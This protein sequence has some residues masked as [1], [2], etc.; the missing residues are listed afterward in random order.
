MGPATVTN[1]H[2]SGIKPTLA[3]RAETVEDL[4]YSHVQ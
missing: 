4:H 2:L 3:Y 1:Q